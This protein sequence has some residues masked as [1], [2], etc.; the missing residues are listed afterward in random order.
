MKKPVII[1]ATLL[2]A[3]CS[4]SSSSMNTTKAALPPE[5]DRAA[6]NAVLAGIDTDN[7][8]VRDD[9]QRLV[10]RSYTS[11]TKRALA[12][13][14]AKEV[15]KIYS[16]PPTTPTQARAITDA[17]SRVS[18]CI[19]SHR[20]IPFEARAGIIETIV[21]AH[22][23]TAAR[24]KEYLNYNRLLHGQTIESRSDEPGICEGVL[25]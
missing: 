8:G 11:T 18:G 13:S 25:K 1:F 9:V 21:S 6:S 2:L 20:E 15:R 16:E 7:D 22:T 19:Y 17:K 12:L 14:F 4:G 23:D 24:M 10:L 5:P 3:A